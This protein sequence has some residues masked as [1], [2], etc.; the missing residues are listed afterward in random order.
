VGV[1]NEVKP[2][3]QTDDENVCSCCTLLLCK[4]LRLGCL[5]MWYFSL[6]SALLGNGLPTYRWS[7]EGR[8]RQRDEGT[9]VTVVCS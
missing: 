6:L 9:T 3:E 1:F 7:A 5:V 2:E 4:E 8:V